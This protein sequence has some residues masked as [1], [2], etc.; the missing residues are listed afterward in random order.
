M[1]HYSQYYDSRTHNSTTDPNTQKATSHSY[2]SHGQYPSS[3]RSQYAPPGLGWNTTLQ[4]NYATAPRQGTHQ[5][6]SW[7][8]DGTQDAAFDGQRHATNYTANDASGSNAHSYHNSANPNT[9]A[10][11]NTQGLNSLAYVSVLDSGAQ[12]RNGH[13]AQHTSLSTASS[14]PS[15]VNGPN[16]INSPPFQLQPQPHSR[17]QSQSMYNSSVGQGT[18]SSY[19]ESRPPNNQTSSSAAA[20]A[21]AGAVSRRYAQSPNP[22][23]QTSMSP[24]GDASRPAIQNVINRTASPHF[25]T[26]SSISHTQPPPAAFQPVNSGAHV[27]NL[28]RSQIGDRVEQEPT[29]A[30]N[31]RRK[32]SHG[33][34]GQPPPINSIFNL[35]T[36]NV[37]NEPSQPLYS[38]ASDDANEMPHYIDPTQVFNPFHKEHE[39]RRREAAQAE[40]EAE[41]R[42]RADADAAERRRSEAEAESR[43]L[44]A[45]ADRLR[46]SEEQAKRQL[47]KAAKPLPGFRKTTPLPKQPPPVETAMSNL[48]ADQVE[49]D[50][51]AEMKAMMERMKVFRSKDPSMFQKLWEDMRKP[52]QQGGAISTAPT[53]SPS[54]HLNQPPTV[55]SPQATQSLKVP[56]SQTNQQPTG[57]IHQDSILHPPKS[58][59]TTTTQQQSADPRP[60]PSNRPP[61][62]SIVENNPEGLP[63]LGRFPAER[64]KR[65]G[66]PMKQ[67]EIL[68]VSMPPAPVS[69][70]AVWPDASQ[71]PIDAAFREAAAGIPH[72]HPPSVAVVTQAASS[73]LPARS[74]SPIIKNTAGTTVW[75]EEKRTA[76]AEAA[77][78]L[79]KGLPDNAHVEVTSSEV[80]AMLEK[81][82]SYIEL[83]ILLESKGLKFHRGQFARQL[84]NSVPYLNAPAPSKTSDSQQT[85]PPAL[86]PQSFTN[87]LSSAPQSSS[88][89]QSTSV[90]GAVGA[91]LASGG[92]PAS[93]NFPTAVPLQF[94]TSNGVVTSVKNERP[95]NRPSKTQRSTPSRPE[96]PAGSKEAMARKR[97][98]SEL[99]DLTALSDTDDYVMSSKHMPPT[100][101]SPEPDSFR[102]YQQQMMSTPAGPAP[103]HP[104]GGVAQSDPTLYPP[105]MNVQ[106]AQQVT[107]PQRVQPGYR[108]PTRILAKPLNHA[109]GLAKNYYDPKNVARDVL[110]ASGR[111]PTERPLNAHMAGLLNRHI[112]IDS[113]L[114]TFDWDAVDPGGPPAP[115]VEYV[116]MTMGSPQRSMKP[117][118]TSNEDHVIKGGDMRAPSLDRCDRD[119]A[120]TASRPPPP[121]VDFLPPPRQVESVV[122]NDASRKTKAILSER[123]NVTSRVQA[124][125]SH[126]RPLSLVS[127]IGRAVQSLTG[128]SK[129]SP[130]PVP[131][132]QPQKRRQSS[133]SSSNLV[134]SPPPAPHP[135]APATE[136]KK[137]SSEAP[138]KRRGRPPGAK[139]KNMSVAA[140][141]HAAKQHA[142]KQ[143]VSV[144]VPSPASA[145]SPVFKCRWKGCRAELHN[146]ITLRQHIV[147]IHQEQEDSQRREEGEETEY[148][149]WWKKCRH[150]T[151][152]ED[153]MVAPSK[154]FASPALWLKHIED[155][156]IYPLTLKYGDGPSSTHIGKQNKSSFEISRFRYTSSVGRADA[157]TFSHL[158]PQTLL[159]E[160]TRFLSDEQGRLATPSVSE[161]SQADLEADTVTLLSA[162]H[163]ETDRQAHRSFMKAHHRQ[164]YTPKSVAE[165]TLR[166]LEVHKARTSG[167]DTDGAILATEARRARLVQNPGIAM[168]VDADD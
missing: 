101:P 95:F 54:P 3:D 77:V 108:P 122:H 141:Q 79:L 168:V 158:D 67:N 13:L 88:P 121:A 131:P 39:R 55:Q 27:R 123:S 106:Q 78:S 40:A 29:P 64:R 32:I 102:D 147:K 26:S 127:A 100:H 160:Q 24:T 16:R 85:Q 140:M 61:H 49:A 157:R 143:V 69:S 38:V 165:E 63:D 132:A 50:M 161:E 146:R 19:Q 145:R 56:P 48:A 135:S 25:Q 76:L 137:M 149:C 139:S 167:I 21:L 51:A 99:I 42:R 126:V 57:V 70:T 36:R 11:Q 52:G 90:T 97:D 9:S 84:L 110:I 124:P 59:A 47:E 14:A 22:I 89:H 17:P 98:F 162:D 164:K 12:Q 80:H 91:S 81:N 154:T 148:L 113:D 133:R 105:P 151:Q 163:D 58:F 4:Q 128:A 87:A 60:Q 144:A 112:T 82:P 66:K 150:L 53:Q 68:D 103:L 10:S 73:Q 129:P 23:G 28:P 83:C 114:S 92:G 93:T 45:E 31:K 155:D 6:N 142:A 96:P 1:G 34:A 44:A 8:N 156:H 15:M 130:G 107:G 153:G 18:H 109:E 2:N 120:Q 159:A 94:Q 136:P 30:P 104:W 138:V 152:F 118:I 72:G 41:A 46:N 20:T 125:D 75:P 62:R 74:Q 111:H 71:D 115:Q 33:N 116:E 43:R 35:V 86:H 134:K 166:A 117:N 37:E 119:C 65:Y 7:Q 5:I